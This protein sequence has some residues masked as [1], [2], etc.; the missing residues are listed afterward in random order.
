MLFINWCGN[1]TCAISPAQL[2]DHRRESRGGSWAGRCCPSL[3]GI[4]HPADLC[5]QGREVMGFNGHLRRERSWSCSFHK[6]ENLLKISSSTETQFWA[7]LPLCTLFTMYQDIHPLFCTVWRNKGIHSA[8]YGILALLPSNF[9]FHCLFS[10][11]IV[12]ENYPFIFKISF[13][14]ISHIGKKSIL[15]ITGS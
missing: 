6:E 5:W 12:H 7:Q 9:V 1:S 3:A 4:D 11:C 13:R 10:R 8:G 14:Y 15:R 2:Q